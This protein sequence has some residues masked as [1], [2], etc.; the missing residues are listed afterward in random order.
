M[1]KGVF[2][3]SAIIASCVYIPSALAQ[4][5]NPP[6]AS[7]KKGIA[8]IVVTAQKRAENVQ[9]VPIAISAYSSEA[10][11]T[12]GIREISQISNVTPNATLDA[13][14]PFS[15]SSQVLAA[16]IR[17]VGANDFAANLDPGVGVY[18][19]GVYLARTVGANLNLPD[20]ERVEILKGPQG[21]LFGRNTIGGAISV[22]TRDPDDEFHFKGD[23]T[24]GRFNRFDARG[25]VNIPVADGLYSS[26]TFS[27]E[28]RDGYQ[29]RVPY[30]TDQPFAVDAPTYIP[31]NDYAVSDRQ[32]GNDSW[33]VRGKLLWEPSSNITVRL[34]GDYSTTDTSSTPNSVVAW[35]EG[36]QPAPFAPPPGTGLPG[37]S[38]APPAGGL[39]FAGLYNF[40]INS[41]ADQIAARF[42]Q[43]LCGMRGT[44]F[45][46]AGLSSALGGVNTDGDPNNNRLT[47]D[48]RFV[49]TDPDR[50]YATGNNYNTLESYGFSGTV[51]I[52]L[53]DQIALKS[54]TGYRNLD[55]GSGVD[56]DNSP[57]DLAEGSLSMQQ[58]QFSQELQVIGAFLDNSLNVVL[59]GYYFEEH[60]S[61]NDRMAF[62]QGLLQIDGPND[63]D[64]DNWA[65]FGQ[66]DWRINEWLGITIGGRYTE[67]NKSLLGAQS[68]LNGLLYKALNCAT[69]DGTVDPYAQIPTG[70]GATAPCYAVAGFPVEDEP[71]RFYVDEKQKKKFSNFSPKFGIQLHP[72]DDLMVYGSYSKG[73]KTG[74]W[75]TRLSAPL[76]YAP[77]FDEEKATTYEVGIKSTLLDRRLQLNAAAFQTDY[78]DIQLTFY[79]GVSPIF[80]NAG[81]ARIKGF[82]IEAVAAPVDG[83]TINASVGYLDAYFK[84]VLDQSVVAPNAF[85]LGVRDGTELPK[86]PEWSL[87]VSPTYVAGL[88]N[89]GD[90]TTSVTW[91]HQTKVFNDV[92][93]T[94]ALARPTH[95]I[96]DGSITY[97]APGREWF[98]QGGVTNI[99]DK[100]VLVTG[101]SNPGF[102]LAFGTYNR[103]REW[104]LRAGVNF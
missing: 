55:W 72:S 39:N 12:R 101:V 58:D 89:G 100:R 32:G 18:L 31:R 99:F 80:Q 65:V 76:S 85:Q 56:L 43:N 34:S 13:G 96:V 63:L 73:Y 9:D 83:L 53:S 103:P 21:T 27:T 15:G 16:F 25:T 61:L 28:Q 67:E 66:I 102:G 29:K 38:F 6:P 77:D 92:E 45:N 17:G 70:P 40:C 91:S 60:A 98:L 87:N 26:L 19:D 75:T 79:S 64:T 2:L 1:K 46:P 44:Q 4:E 84:D 36:F 42:A 24:Y 23:V 22:V 90:I 5:N 11:E 47:Y 68:D 104:Y 57:V 78:K 69:P 7:D 41:T 94:E 48:G 30:P 37:T 51:D 59:G 86:T 49:S 82:E 50:S 97:N 54:I 95:D 52:D 14:T 35:D 88:A 74:G 8:E 10:L 3:S 33:T 93:R 20:V 62:G 81:N 71:L